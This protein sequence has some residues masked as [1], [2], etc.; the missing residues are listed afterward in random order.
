MPGL[1][2]GIGRFAGDVLGAIGSVTPSGKSVIKDT[3]ASIAKIEALGG[4]R[5]RK[6]AFA[7]GKFAAGRKEL[8]GVGKNTLGYGIMGA[9]AVS[10]AASN[11]STGAYR[12]APR[13]MTSAPS[14][15]GRSA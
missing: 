2:A 5:A 13:P 10:M 11:R 15:I 14:G 7:A 6:R 1:R 4:N 8:I 12:P 9:S 3:K